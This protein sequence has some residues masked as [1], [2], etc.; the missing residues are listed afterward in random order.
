MAFEVCRQAYALQQAV[1]ARAHE[2]ESSRAEEARQSKKKFLARKVSMDL[3]TAASEI[4]GLLQDAIQANKKS[5]CYPQSVVTLSS[6][7]QGLRAG[8]DEVMVHRHDSYYKYEPASSHG[9]WLCI[10]SSSDVDAMVAKLYA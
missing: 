5:G 7:F 1:N 2:A 10:A 8:A 3:R 9:R 4:A 6:V